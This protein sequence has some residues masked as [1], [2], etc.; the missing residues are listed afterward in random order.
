MPLTI[1]EKMKYNKELAELE[2]KLM[3]PESN[4]DYISGMIAA[5]RRFLGYKS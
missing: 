1:T 2:Q 4:H 3:D 5:Y